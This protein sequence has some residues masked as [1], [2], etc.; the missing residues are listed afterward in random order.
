MTALEKLRKIPNLHFL[1]SVRNANKSACQT[2][3]SLQRCQTHRIEI[4]KIFSSFQLLIIFPRSPILD[5]YET[6]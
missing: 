3:R 1:I 5:E 2:K 4:L 6:M